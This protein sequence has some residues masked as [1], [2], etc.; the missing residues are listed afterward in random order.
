MPGLIDNAVEFFVHDN[1]VKCLN[2]G[3]VYKYNEFPQWILNRIETDMLENPEALKALGKWEN[4]AISDHKRQ[5][6]YCRFGGADLEPD[7]DVNGEINHSEYFDCGF[8]G[9]C[10]HEG[11]LCSSIKVD[12][13]H[14]TKTEIKVL[15]NI[16]L[17]EKQIADKLNMSVLTVNSHTQNLREKTGLSTKTELAV[18]ASRKGII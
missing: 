9:I 15:Q 6:I 8:R 11:K 16:E 2:N 18:F 17:L 7:I 1:E 12:N 10:K 5:Y 3:T 14:L 4:L 13:G